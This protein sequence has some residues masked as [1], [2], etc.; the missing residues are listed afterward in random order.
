MRKIIL[1]LLCFSITLWAE[2]TPRVIH[3]FVA[4]CDNATQGIVP[5]PAKIGNGN[6]PFNNLYWGALYGIKTHFRKSPQWKLVHSE[7]IDDMIL[8]RAVFKHQSSNVYMVADAYKGSQI[9][10]CI[11]DFAN[12]TAGLDQ[13]SYSFTKSD[14]KY[15]IAIGGS[16]NLISYLGHD[17]LIEFEIENYP[18]PADSLQREAIILACISQTYFSL[19]LEESGAKPLLWTTDFMAPEAY[20]LS[21]A[22]EGWIRKE[23]DAAIRLRAAQAYNKYQKCGLKG[24]KRLLVTGW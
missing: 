15:T 14:R 19:V 17:G 7:K 8:E 21:A 11:Q 4:L 1:L 5:V 13:K 23:S 3:T 10:Q 6:D 20:T 24:A 22:L 2:S 12:A 16:A 18:Q 9:K